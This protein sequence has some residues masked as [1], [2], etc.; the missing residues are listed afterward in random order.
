MTSNAVKSGFTG[1]KANASIPAK[2]PATKIAN[3][4]TRNPPV[5]PGSLDTIPYQGLLYFGFSIKEF[6]PKPSLIAKLLRFNNALVNL[7][8]VAVQTAVSGVVV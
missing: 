5:E 7:A 4:K 2:N 8:F 1:I 3:P 6:S